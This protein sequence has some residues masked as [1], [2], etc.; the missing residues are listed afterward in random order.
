MLRTVLA[1]LLWMP[2]TLVAADAPRI[3][4]SIKP[5]HSLVSNLLYGITEADLLLTG[6]QSPHNHQLKPSEAMRL[7]SADVI[8][9]VGPA[10]ESFLPNYLRKLTNKTII[11]LATDEHTD[12]TTHLHTDPHRWLDPVLAIK[13][14]QRIAQQ[15]IVRYPSLKNRIVTN[16]ELLTQRLLALDHSLSGLFAS[17]TEISA[18]LY[19]D[20]WSYFTRRYHLGI[21]GI[22]NPQP[23]SQPGGRHL[24]EI[25]QTV[26]SK[27]TRCLLIEP[28]FKPRYLDSLATN[29]GTTVRLVDPLGADEPAGIN[30]YFNIMQANAG[31][32]ARCR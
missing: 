3:I 30:A 28:Q 13:D 14:S 20:A 18:L 8:I 4:V 6:L 9:W 1:L 12:V 7:Y 26:A 11:T 32:F 24:N 10:L 5:V 19:H 29:P 15:L 16:L 2:F 27:G 17:G 22:I 25:Q 31:T 21:H 23:H